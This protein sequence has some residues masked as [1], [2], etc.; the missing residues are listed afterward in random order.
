[1]QLNEIYNVDVLDGLRELEDSSIDLIITSPPYNK[2]G[3]NGFRKASNIWNRCITYGGEQNADNMP[4]EDYQ[5]WQ[6]EILNECFR[7]LK[8]DGSMWYN[9]KDRIVYKKGYVISPL[10]WIWQSPFLVR[11]E[12]I[13]NRTATPNVDVKRFMPVVEKIYFLTKTE[14]PRFVRSKD[15]Q[16]K[17]DVWTFQAD[18]NTRHPAPFPIVLPDNIIPSVAQG[19]RITVLDIFSG[20]GTVAVSAYRNGC[21]YLGFEKYPEYVEMAK[22]RLEEEKNKL[23]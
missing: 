16:F 11:Q 20:S 19:E 13:W 3:L 9:H 10:K 23:F 21:D 6:I 7:V 14:R 22:R 4:E 15:C 1:M 2:T 5:K 18:K 12:I 17:T 8:D